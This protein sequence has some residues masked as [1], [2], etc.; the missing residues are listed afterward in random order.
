MARP[1]L[2]RFLRAGDRAE[3]GIVVSSKGLPAS[4]VTVRAAVNGLVIEGA[5]ERSVDL[6]RD[7]SVEVRFPMR[8]DQVGDASLRFDVSA[9]AVRDAVIVRR[10]GQAPGV[11]ESVALYGSTQKGVSERLGDYTT[12]RHHTRGL[13]LSLASSAL[14]RPDGGAAPLL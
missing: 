12:I 7:Q 2:P 1:S 3:A 5:P 13:T 8:A 9:G 4:R 10:R 14:G 11:L 6:A